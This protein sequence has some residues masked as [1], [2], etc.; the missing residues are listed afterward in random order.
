[1]ARLGSSLGAPIN[2]PKLAS[3]VAMH[4][5]DD[6][7]ARGWP[8]GTV[9]GSET[10][11]LERYGV[12]RAVLRE[13]VRIIEHS[14]AARMR[15]GP[16]GGLVVSEPNRGAVVAAIGVWLSYVGIT[17]TQM[18]EVRRPLMMA[19]AGLAAE[20]RDPAA[21][22]ELL[23]RLDQLEA[24][25]GIGPLQL[26]ELERAIVACAR[27]PAVELFTAALADIGIGQLGNGKA[28]LDPPLTPEVALRHLGTYRPTVDAIAAG[29]VEG[30]KANMAL[31]IDAVSRRLRDAKPRQ[32]R[33]RLDDASTGKLAERVAAV[34]RDDIEQ[35]GWPIGEVLGSETE[36]IE[37]YGVSRAVLREATRILEHHGAVRTKR[38]PN[39]GLLVTEPDVAAVVRSAQMVLEHDR[40]DVRQLFEARSIIEVAATRMAAERRT[41]AAAAELRA[42]VEAEGGSGDAGQRFMPVH[43]QIA[44][45]SGNQLYVLFVD[46]MGE[47]VPSHV[48]PDHR[49]PAG[50][51]EL[52]G[53]V[54][55]AHA[56]IAEAV[57]AGDADLAER[58]MTRHLQASVGVLQ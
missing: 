22:A 20:R 51:A 3:V 7:M 11:L 23:A 16:G 27:N 46:V 49:T 53:V 38:G 28:R 47:L 56:R 5:E 58:R 50:M 35:A 29:D 13:A 45:A 41:D 26:S 1:M 25:G 44:T 42:A 55:H 30:A 12:S 39:G 18:F 2:A 4:I 37:R 14:G 43:R 6:V 31:T 8:V 17:I 34:L 24:V 19:A 9:L 21:G 36:L 54:H 10:E 52:S 57:I 32:Q 15:R 48:G 33:L 40:I